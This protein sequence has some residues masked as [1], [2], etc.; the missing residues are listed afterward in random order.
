MYGRA[1]SDLRYERKSKDKKRSIKDNAVFE[2]GRGAFFDGELTYII[3][4]DEGIP[5]LMIYPRNAFHK[6]ERKEFA[7]KEE[8]IMEIRAALEPVLK[9]KDRYDDAYGV[10]FDG[11]GWD[12]WYAY[13]GERIDKSGYVEY[14]S[15][16]RETIVALQALMEK[17]EKKYAGDT[18]SEEDAR[19]RMS[20]W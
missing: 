13:K 15:D 18:Y 19:Q 10:I 12:I 17:L 5:I 3:G 2:F 7:I 1:I 11:H 20:L 4:F 8:D 9:W 14:P 6:M 16:Y